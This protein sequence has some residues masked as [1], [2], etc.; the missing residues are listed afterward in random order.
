M[1]IG[2]N[3]KKS[4]KGNFSTSKRNISLSV[5]ETL[6]MLRELHEL[7]QS[8]LAEKTD[9]PQSTISGIENDRIK[10][11]VQRA[12]VFA[13]FLKVHPAVILF[14]SWDTEKESSKAA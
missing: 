8:D 2:K 13:R 10:L 3:L 12:K 5:G 4:L 9:I 14:P 11:G 1:S 7:S 6:K